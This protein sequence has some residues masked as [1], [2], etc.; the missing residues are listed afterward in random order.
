MHILCWQRLFLLVSKTLKTL[1]A[2]F[3]DSWGGGV[4]VGEH[5][6]LYSL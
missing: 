4:R 5:L 6:F 1:N 3:R 2:Y